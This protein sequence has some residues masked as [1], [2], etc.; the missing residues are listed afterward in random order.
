MTSETFPR[1][2]PRKPVSARCVP[3]IHMKTMAS[4][5][6]REPVDDTIVVDADAHAAEEEWPVSDL[7]LVEQESGQLDL[8]PEDDTAPFVP[9]EAQTRRRVPVRAAGALLLLAVVSAAIA[10]A[11][12][13]LRG[14]EAP[15]RGAS[16]GGDAGLALAGST[17]RPGTVETSMTSSPAKEAL[18]KLEGMRVTEAR[19]VLEELGARLRITRVSSP[20]PRGVVLSQQP[21]SGTPIDRGSVVTLVVSSG[22]STTAASAVTVPSLV[23]RAAR[24]ASEE[25]RRRG[26][27]PRIRLVASSDSAGI[28][29]SQSPREGTHVKPGSV[30]LLEV[31]RER[32]VPRRVEVPDVVGLTLDDARR[33]LR[34]LGLAVEV[35]HVQSSQ[36]ESTVLRQSPRAGAEVAEKGAVTLTVSSG[37]ETIDVPDVTGLGE[38]SAREQLASAGFE[39]T[40][41]YEPT[42]DPAQ[43][44]MVARQTPPGGATATA[45][46][47][48]TLV[49]TRLG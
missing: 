19:A 30:V 29:L 34:P 17:T 36:P 24:D 9:P 1:P 48:V 49:V 39:V 26:L 21:A 46:T 38:A 7:Y 35:V 22:A 44:G 25:I 14:G 41:S 16:D 45:G 47:T 8:Q 12:L 28:V 3:G 23:G 40:V 20:K 15:A 5:S 31:S 11:A 27:V 43:D 2:V 13:A 32:P 37:P 42:S 18:P 33:R 4:G 6:Q 10:V